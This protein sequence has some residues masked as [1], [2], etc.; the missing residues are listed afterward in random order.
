MKEKKTKVYKSGSLK[1]GIIE[2]VIASIILVLTILMIIGYGFNNIGIIILYIVLFAVFGFMMSLGFVDIHNG[3]IRKVLLKYGIKDVGKLLYKTRVA[4]LKKS[5]IYRFQYRYQ[6][7]DYIMEEQIDPKLY[8]HYNEGKNI[9]IL[10]YD[11]RAIIDYEKIFGK[12]YY[13]K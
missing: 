1:N 6:N 12:N 2:V 9:P 11:K 13:K 3:R 7:K 10:V 5:N 8:D 4:G